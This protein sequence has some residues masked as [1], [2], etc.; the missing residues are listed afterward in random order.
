LDVV[1]LGEQEKIYTLISEVDLKDILGTIGEFFSEARRAGIV[2]SGRR[3]T[4]LSRLLRVRALRR[5]VSSVDAADLEDFI[6]LGDTQEDQERIRHI[7]ASLSKPRAGGK[8]TSSEMSLSAEESLDS[9]RAD[10]SQHQP[11]IRPEPE[12]PFIFISYKREDIYIIEKYL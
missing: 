9:G 4:S 3:L 7:L 5:M 2:I 6:F 11:P 10:L 8:A 12:S 1:S